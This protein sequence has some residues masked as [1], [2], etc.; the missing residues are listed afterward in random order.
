MFIFLSSCTHRSRIS[1]KNC[2]T[3]GL[4]SETA[5][6]YKTFKKNYLFFGFEK[7]FSLNELLVSKNIECRK[8]KYINYTWKQGPVDSLI[9][10]IPFVNQKTLVVNYALD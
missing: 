6:N 10:I 1:T 4:Y 9:S 5:A 2:K 3:T 8:I 7:E